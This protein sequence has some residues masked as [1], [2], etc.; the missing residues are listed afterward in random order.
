ME[1]FDEEVDLGSQNAQTDGL[2]N[3]EFSAGQTQD[4]DIFNGYSD[5]PNPF[6]SEQSHD[7]FVDESKDPFYDQPEPIKI[8]P[9]GRPGVIQDAPLSVEDAEEIE[10]NRLR[11]QENQ[12]RMAKL[13]AKDEKERSAKD[14]KRAQAKQELKK[15]YEDRNKMTEMKRDMNREE[16]TMKAQ[17][18]KEYTD[19][20][21][22]K[23][24][25]SMIDFKEDRKD[26][27]RMKSVLLSKKNEG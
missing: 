14:A 6:E 16:E 12:A 3:F 22:W 23:K 18:K 2:M 13:Y 4:Q 20:T 7:I 26:V 11:D 8:D 1:G 15:W 27:Q 9:N 25:A 19:A 5:R 24:V 17:Q 21:S 10:R